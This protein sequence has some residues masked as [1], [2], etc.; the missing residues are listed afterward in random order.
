MAEVSGMSLSAARSTDLSNMWWCR[1]ATSP[2]ILAPALPQWKHSASPALLSNLKAGI[3]EMQSCLCSL[4]PIF[5]SKLERNSW[6]FEVLHPLAEPLTQ[7]FFCC[8]LFLLWLLKLEG[9]KWSHRKIVLVVRSSKKLL[10][11]CGRSIAI[12][13][14]CLA[15]GAIPVNLKSRH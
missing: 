10:C 1:L 6:R 4:S 11:M 3:G 7:L 14:W 9:I 15:V 13:S 8:D 2:P 5:L 12:I